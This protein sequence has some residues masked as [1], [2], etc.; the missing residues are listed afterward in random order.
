[1]PFATEAQLIAYYPGLGDAAL[2]AIRPIALED[3]ECKFDETTWGCSLKLGHI[4]A[5]AHMLYKWM[6][7]QAAGTGGTGGGS[8]GGQVASKTMGPVSI[9][10]TATVTAGDGDS[11]WSTTVPGQEYLRLRDCLGPQAIVPEVQGGYCRCY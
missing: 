3:A 1:M 11:F 5:T 10:Y 4:H 7:T 2:D 8:V 9:S 6:E